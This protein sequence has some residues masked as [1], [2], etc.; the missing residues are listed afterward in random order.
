MRTLLLLLSP[1]SM[2]GQSFYL[3]SSTLQHIVFQ[4]FALVRLDLPIATIETQPPVTAG[5]PIGLGISELS[6]NLYITITGHSTKALS[7]SASTRPGY[8]L[9]A[10]AAPPLT[11]ASNLDFQLSGLPTHMGKLSP[12]TAASFPFTLRLSHKGQY[13][14]LHQQQYYAELQLTLD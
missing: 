4:D 11:E 7:A 3:T 8:S 14:E 10:T 9:V 5:K 2:F 12:G 1:L 6:A 13:H